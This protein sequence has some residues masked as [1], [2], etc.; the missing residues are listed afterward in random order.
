MSRELILKVLEAGRIAPSAFNSQPWHFIVVENREHIERIAGTQEWAADAPA[1]IVLLGLDDPENS[2]GDEGVGACT[3]SR[4]V[5]YHRNRK[6]LLDLGIAFEHVILA[7]TDLGLGTCWMGIP[8]GEDSHI[9]EFLGVP[10]EYRVLARTPIGLPDEE[11]QPVS[12]RSMDEVVSWES[13]GNK[14]HAGDKSRCC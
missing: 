11:P 1:M 5:D 8:W 9:K 2:L 3:R 4:I 10:D 12:R 6:Y 7:A 13:Y 14:A